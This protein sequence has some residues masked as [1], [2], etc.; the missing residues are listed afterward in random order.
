MRTAFFRYRYVAAAAFLLAAAACS[1][2]HVSQS[3]HAASVARGLLA[4]GDTAQA[5]YHLERVDLESQRDPSLFLLVGRFY[6]ETGTIV[7][8][9]QSQMVLERG[10]QLFPDDVRL[11]MELGKT[12]YSQTFY[13][14]AAKCMTEVLSRDP[15]LCEAHYYLG[16]YHYR[17][18]KR[19]NQYTDD[20]RSA[21]GHFRTAVDCDP[22]NVSAVLKHLYCLYALH[23]KD[24]AVK[25]CA[26]AIE[27]LPDVPELI[28]VRAA[29]SY[30]DERFKKAAADFDRALG[31][32]DPEEYEAYTD[33]SSLLP[34]EDRSVYEA[35]SDAKRETI[36]REFWTE[37]DPDPTTPINERRLEHTYRMFLADL[38]F[39]IERSSIR[40]W[41]TERGATFVKFGWPWSITS[42]LGD[43]WKTGR[44]EFWNY[45]LRGE[46]RQFVFVDEFLNGNLRIPIAADSMV[47]V[48]RYDSPVSNYEAEATP[49]PGDI[50]V[51]TFKNDDLSSAIYIAVSMNADS[52][53]KSADLEKADYFY[54]RGSLFDDDWTLEKNFADT[55]WT[56]EVYVARDS[57]GQRYKLIRNVEMPFGFYHVACAFQDEFGAAK[58][59]FKAYG[60]AYRYVGDGLAVSDILLQKDSAPNSP[61][62]VRAGK[63]LYPNPG[64]RY[65]TGERLVVYFEIYNLQAAGQKNNYDVSFHIFESPEEEPSRWRRLGARVAALAGLPA[66]KKPAI[67]QTFERRGEGFMS[68]EDI[69]INIDALEAGRYEL[70]VSIDDRLSGEN[71]QSTTVFVKT[72]APEAQDG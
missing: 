38:Y 9:L 48:L 39:S 63:R 60:N 40:G 67:S 17:N 59:L 21:R 36:E 51:T 13:A 52:L 19:V 57:G 22:S 25:Y 68:R 18:W 28:L 58:S 69:A 45:P 72:A 47:A 6:R 5:V 65:N 61:A 35:A 7:G 43:S 10:V 1:R 20:L 23:E 34:Y 44:I 42:T 29:L 66:G 62:F 15:G 26:E 4:L 53:K 33:I 49:I 30:D 37:A 50:S 8:R 27:R 46:I 32:I 11:R 41:E 14:D 31:L 64:R 2:F 54:F 71:T 24:A 12:Y 55:L 56:S 16:L 70:V 3:P